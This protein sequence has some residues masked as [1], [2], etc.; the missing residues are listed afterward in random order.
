[1]A[2]GWGLLVE[3]CLPVPFVLLI[4]LTVPAPRSFN[5]T[6]LT[7]VDRTLGVRFVGTFSLLHIM[8]VVTGAAFL[9]TIRATM[10]VS[11]ERRGV[12]G[13]EET[14]GMIASHLAK[15]WRNERNFWISFICFVLW[16]LLAR[17][18]KIM[19]DK[20][21]LEDRIRALSGP[22]AAT[23]PASSPPP[24]STVPKKTS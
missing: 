16:C 9:A 8:L 22:G 7:L 1:M 18:H 10:G 20:A 3:L 15:K 13:G 23:K 24:A 12:T 4:L 2:G 19:V 11:K 6:V 5:R 21:Q 14:P 17:L